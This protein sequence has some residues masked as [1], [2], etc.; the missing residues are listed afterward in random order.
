MK[1]E[2]FGSDKNGKPFLIKAQRTY[3]DKEQVKMH[4]A[5]VKIFLYGDKETEI[6]AN[7]GVAVLEKK[8]IFLNKKVK[9]QMP[10]GDMVDASSIII[11]YDKGVISSNKPVIVHSKND[12]I[13]ANGFKIVYSE[14]EKN[15]TFYGSVKANILIN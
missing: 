8:Q 10:D 14:K 1:S 4:N 6:T 2:I 13:S 7:E 9:I 11:E 5:Y 15:I 3:Y 12:K